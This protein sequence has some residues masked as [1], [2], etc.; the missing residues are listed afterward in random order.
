MCSGGCLR[1]HES[2]KHAGHAGDA[3][4]QTAILRVQTSIWR[5]TG[6]LKLGTLSSTFS[7]SRIGNA[8]VIDN[9]YRLQVYKFFALLGVIENKVVYQDSFEIAWGKR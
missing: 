1:K 8:R 4:V 6:L 7:L 3:G 9:E 5:A 2:R